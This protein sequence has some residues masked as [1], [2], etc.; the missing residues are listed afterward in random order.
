MLGQAVESGT[1][2]I[3]PCT[4]SPIESNAK[5]SRDILLTSSHPPRYATIQGYSPAGIRPCLEAGV[6]FVPAEGR[7]AEGELHAGPPSSASVTEAPCQNLDNEVGPGQRLLGFAPICLLVRAS[8]RKHGIL[9]AC[10]SMRPLASPWFDLLTNMEAVVDG[11]N[12]N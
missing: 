4:L 12:F 6:D 1:R 7:I 9:G 3:A 11:P 2:L 5:H 10:R 8:T